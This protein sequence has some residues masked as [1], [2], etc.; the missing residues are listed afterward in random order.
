M[1]CFLKSGKHLSRSATITL[2]T[3]VS[4]EECIELIHSFI[5]SNGTESPQYVQLLYHHPCIRKSLLSEPLSS[6]GLYSF[7]LKFP[8]TVRA[9]EEDHVG[10]QAPEDPHD[11]STDTCLTFPYGSNSPR[12]FSP[13][14]VHPVT[15]SPIRVSPLFIATS[16][17][18]SNN[19]PIHRSTG[20][21]SPAPASS[22]SPV[23]TSSQTFTSIPPSQ[24]TNPSKIPF[25]TPY[26][27]SS[28]PHTGPIVFPGGPPE[29]P[30]FGVPFPG[31][32]STFSETVF[33]PSYPIP[34]MVTPTAKPIPF[35]PIESQ[36]ITGFGPYRRHGRGSRGTHSGRGRAP[37]C[38]RGRATSTTNCQ[39]SPIPSHPWPNHQPSLVPSRGPI[40]GEALNLATMPRAFDHFPVSLPSSPLHYDY[41]TVLRAASPVVIF[42]CPPQFTQKSFSSVYSISFPHGHDTKSLLVTGIN[43]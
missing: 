34:P 11:S 3:A 12:S 27:S 38:R 40:A 41:F 1:V 42:H 16:N 24:T 18:S 2:L 36:S 19:S 39:T 7:F 17:S 35:F 22:T 25:Y 13:S 6:E 20:H 28:F 8:E 21:N 32:C 14:P 23:P 15:D 9:E 29:F 5:R 31:T 37:R 26:F 4:A 43:Q 10:L 30:Y 33:L